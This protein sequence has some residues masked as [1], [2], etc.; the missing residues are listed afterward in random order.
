MH[1]SYRAHPSLS[2]PAGTTTAHR[3]ARTF[4]C[5]LVCFNRVLSVE[6]SGPAMADYRTVLSNIVYVL[7]WPTDRIIRAIKYTL[8]PF[9]TL[10]TFVFLPV[11]YLVQT[12]LS[13]VLFPFRVDVLERV[14]TIY[15]WLGVAALVGC[16]TG[17]VLYL[18]YRGLTSALNIDA[19]AAAEPKKAAP[20]GKTIEQ[21]RAA[22]REKRGAEFDGSSS[23]TTL[24]S[25]P[26]RRRGISSSSYAIMEEESEF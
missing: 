9:W 19:S 12:V 6:S 16:I 26:A 1:A 13:I 14:E 20:R 7:W 11:T 8:S 25:K 21:F 24:R 3:L 23:S 18:I 5:L 17:G 15:I 2:S 22:R 10:I 4:S